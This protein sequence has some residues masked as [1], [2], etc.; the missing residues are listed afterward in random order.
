MGYPTYA[1]EIVDT[2]SHATSEQSLGVLAAELKRWSRKSPHTN[3]LEFA[4][5]PSINAPIPELPSMDPND[6]RHLALSLTPDKPA[7]I[8]ISQHEGWLLMAKSKIRLDAGSDVPSDR[9][10]ADLEEEFRSL[11]LHKINEW[12]RQQE[13]LCLRGR[14]ENFFGSITRPAVCVSVDTGMRYGPSSTSWAL[15]L[16]SSGFS[17][18]EPPFDRTVDINVL[19]PYGDTPSDV[20]AF[21]RRLHILPPMY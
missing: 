21:S 18:R 17:W 20:R 2:A 10:L 3:G 14:L 13:I 11:Q 6:P 4:I 8:P 1:P 15:T 7:N 5:Q 12:R 16:L 19:C 9:L